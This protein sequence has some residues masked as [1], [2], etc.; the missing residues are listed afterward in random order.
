MREG[1]SG[2]SGQRWRGRR[3][4]QRNRTGGSSS[5]GCSP[6]M[7]SWVYAIQRAYGRAGVDA[8]SQ[9]V[10][11]PPE[12]ATQRLLVLHVHH[13]ECVGVWA[14]C[15]R[16]WRPPRAPWGSTNPRG[17][18]GGG[19]DGGEGREKGWGEQRGR[20]RG[21]RR[22]GGGGR[23]REEEEEERGTSSIGVGEGAG[24]GKEEG[25][26]GGEGGGEGSGEGG[27]RGEKKGGAGRRGEG[28]RERPG[29][30]IH[31]STLT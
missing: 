24:D 25:E 1:A 12:P 8:G 18:G 6:T 20:G 14:A 23:G 2:W 26:R 22:G 9:C 3:A 19:S 5:D 27:K 11:R 29:T 13:R 10:D 4:G 31:S 16:R 17:G 30:D 28:Q 15:R 21:E 7:L